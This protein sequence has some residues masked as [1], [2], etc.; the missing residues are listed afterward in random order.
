MVGLRLVTDQDVHFSTRT[1][2]LV[3]FITVQYFYQPIF[4]LFS[5]IKNALHNLVIDLGSAQKMFQI[6]SQLFIKVTRNFVAIELLTFSKRL[7]FHFYCSREL[8]VFWLNKLYS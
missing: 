3:H 1:L 2:I 5:N 6:Y 7:K 4:S 8:S